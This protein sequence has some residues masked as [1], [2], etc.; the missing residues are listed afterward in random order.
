MFSKKNRMLRRE[1]RMAFWAEFK[2]FAIKGNAMD[3]PTFR[4]FHLYLVGTGLLFL[5]KQ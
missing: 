2:T 4:G 1:K 5:K 3:L